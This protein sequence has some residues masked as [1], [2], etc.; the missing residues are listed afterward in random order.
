MKRRTFGIAC[1]VAGLVGL[2]VTV[3]TAADPDPWLMV[4]VGP[5]ETCVEMK[6]SDYIAQDLNFPYTIWR[7]DGGPDCGSDGHA[8]KE[9]IGAYD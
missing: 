4:C 5:P 9:G 1:I 8:C 3:T 7:G 2:A 6:L